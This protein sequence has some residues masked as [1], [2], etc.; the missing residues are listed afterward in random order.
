MIES[1]YSVLNELDLLPRASEMPCNIFFLRKINI[2]VFIDKKNFFHV[3]LSRQSSLSNEYEA[4][5]QAFSLWPA[6]VPQPLALRRRDG[7]ELLICRGIRHQK[8]L[9][10]DVFGLTQPLFKSLMKFFEVSQK[11]FL[12]KGRQKPHSIAIRDI[13]RSF[14]GMPFMPSIEEWLS[15]SGGSTIDNLPHVKQH[16]DLVV[17]NI[18]VTKL[19]FAIFDWEDFGGVVLPGFDLATL[20][21]SAMEFDPE[22]IIG[23]IIAKTDPAVMRMLTAYCRVCGIDQEMFVCMLPIYLMIFLYLKET[24]GYAMESR[25]MVRRV[26]EAICE[27]RSS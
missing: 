24:E 5:R 17:G 9:P 27:R 13:G 21:C 15:S 25:V 12:S 11:H 4:L 2:Q 6:M 26:I 19:G 3:K 16:G 18:G 7:Y 14:V 10:A 20:L 1:I 22:R 23:G 8:A